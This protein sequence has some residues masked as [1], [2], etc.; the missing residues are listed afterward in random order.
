MLFKFGTFWQTFA[1]V[2][3]SWIF[4]GIWDFEF[5]TITL[6]ALILASK[7]QNT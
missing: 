7:I 5:A 6:L 4:Y 1:I 3:V 2:L